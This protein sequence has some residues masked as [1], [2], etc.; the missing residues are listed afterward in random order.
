MAALLLDMFI[1]DVVVGLS[2][3]PLQRMFDLG[4]SDI[5]DPLMRGGELGRSTVTFLGVYFA[6]ALAIWALYFVLFVGMTGQ[7]PGKKMLG[8]QVVTDDGSAM[9]YSAALVRFA[10]YALSAMPMFLGF[11]WAFFDKNRQA[12]HDKLAHT[13]VV[14]K[15]S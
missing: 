1:L 9:D 13:L 6:L 3:L 11:Y 7:T 12:W 2:T 10:G 14:R 4:V 8:L 15:T 5:L